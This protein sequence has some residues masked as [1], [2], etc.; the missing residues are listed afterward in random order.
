MTPAKAPEK[1]GRKHVLASSRSIN[2]GRA[3]RLQMMAPVYPPARANR[4]S[5]SYL[6]ELQLGLPP[7]VGIGIEGS[8]EQPSDVSG[9]HLGWC[10]RA[11]SAGDREAALLSSG[12]RSCGTRSLN[13]GASEGGGAC[14]GEESRMGLGLSV[15]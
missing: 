13:G 2:A 6:L 11:I 10:G 15:S 1:R 3:S 12:L 5:T 4:E 9:I 8:E 14:A 7:M